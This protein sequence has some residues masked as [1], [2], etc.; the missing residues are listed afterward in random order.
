MRHLKVLGILTLG[1][2]VLAGIAAASAPPAGYGQSRFRIHSLEDQ[3]RLE[4]PGGRG[5]RI[6]VSIREVDEDDVERQ[7]LGG[8][9]GAVIEDVRKDGPAAEAGLQPGDV[10]VEFD[11]ERV[12]SARQLSRLVQETPAGRT[13]RLT[14]MREGRQV[15]VEV[16]PDVGS[17]LAIFG[18]AMPQIDISELGERLRGLRI[19]IPELPDFHMPEIELLARVQPGR[20]GASV[21]DLPPQLADYFGVRGGLL[22][23]NVREDSAAARAGLQAGDVITGVD[24]EPVE[25]GADLRRRLMGREG[26]R[27]TFRLSVVRD[28]QELTLEATLETGP[29]RSLRRTP[30]RRP[31]VGRTFDR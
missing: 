20:L 11:G 13:V 2:T 27:R 30:L 1:S 4:V 19:N 21:Q 16:T 15:G 14:L 3:R 29:D 26:D 23:T 18:G 31:L 12:R 7:K 9:A 8:P 22:V 6:G 25:T 5:S 10:V 17:R 24:G 28:R